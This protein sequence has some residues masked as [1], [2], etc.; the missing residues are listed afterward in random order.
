MW[1]LK[2]KKIH[3]SMFGMWKREGKRKGYRGGNMTKIHYVY[4][5]VVM[6]PIILY[7]IH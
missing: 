6:K 2:R 4:G 3:E 1:N 7:N 5:D